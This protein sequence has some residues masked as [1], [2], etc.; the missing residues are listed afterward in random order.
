MTVIIN[1]L[2]SLMDLISRFIGYKQKKD[3]DA[4]KKKRLEE[5][6]EIIKNQSETEKQ[7]NK[8]EIDELNKK[9]D[10]NSDN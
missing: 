6:D 4:S 1:L 5:L 7:I 10:W 8:G 9:F 2:K 3:L